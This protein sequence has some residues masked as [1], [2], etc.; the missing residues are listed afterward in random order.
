MVKLHGTKRNRE[1]EE[2]EEEEKGNDRCDT[3]GTEDESC[4]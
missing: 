2:E 3:R 1:E 4:H